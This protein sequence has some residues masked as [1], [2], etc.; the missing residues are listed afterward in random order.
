MSDKPAEM[1]AEGSHG[2]AVHM[3]QETLNKGGWLKEDGIFGPATADAVK[4]FQRSKG[5]APDGIV[6]PLTQGALAGKPAA[7]A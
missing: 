4:A 7:K 6:G 2:D 3:V 5:L 1:L